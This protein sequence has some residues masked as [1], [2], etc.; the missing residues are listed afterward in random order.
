[1]SPLSP[2]NVGLR[3]AASAKK[4]QRLIN[5]L[6]ENG[7]PNARLDTIPVQHTE[8][9]H[10]VNVLLYFRPGHRYRYGNV[11]IKYDTTSPVKSRVADKVILSQLYID[12]GHWYKLSEIQRSEAALSKLGTF[13]FFR[14]SLDTTHLSR[15]PD[16]A[17]RFLY[18]TCRGFFTNEK[19]LGNFS[20][21]IRW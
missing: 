9:F 19:A 14:V 4:F 13:D 20:S 10:D 21:D 7:Y 16:F 12:S 3:A 8:G 1:M 18:R 6:I 2:V 11:N 17:P 15:I 5:I